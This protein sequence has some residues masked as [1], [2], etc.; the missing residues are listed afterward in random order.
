MNGIRDIDAPEFSRPFR[1]DE[2]LDDERSLTITAGAGECAALA[3]R[4]GFIDISALG[5][6][7]RLSRWRRK[8]V[9]I[10][11]RLTASLTQRCSVT[12]E[13]V[14]EQVDE[15]LEALYW[16][17][18]L[19]GALGDDGRHG[20]AFSDLEHE[21]IPELFEGD[22]IDLGELAAEWLAL[23]V[24]PYPRLEGAELPAAASEEEA[25]GS[26]S[27]DSP[28]RILSNLNTGGE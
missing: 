28:F 13:P 20:E 17:Q 9:R 8:G 23:S 26:G 5:A 19:A 14:P 1:A 18:A 15:T 4:F 24:D 7:M 27:G 16:P 2:V 22:F 11:G 12:L 25:G 10:V 21:E 3:E 6:E